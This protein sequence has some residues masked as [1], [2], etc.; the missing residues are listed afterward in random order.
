MKSTHYP[1]PDLNQPARVVILGAA[2]TGILTAVFLQKRH[3]D[4]FISDSGPISPEF[5]QDIQALQ[6]PFEEHGHQE[7]TLKEAD[8][9]IAS[10]G[11]PLL[12]KPYQI[13]DKYKIPVISEIEL[14][15]FFNASRIIAVTG[16]NGKSTTVTLI[17]Q[18]LDD[19]G[20]QASCGGNIGIPM[21]SL[22]DKKLDFIV[23]ELSSFQLETTYSLRPEIAILLNVYENHLDRHKD[24]ETYFQAKQRLFQAQ[25]Q[26]EHAILNH[27]NPWCRKVAQQ[28]KAQIHWFGH[29][30]KNGPASI[31][32]GTL[33]YQNQPLMPLSELALSG[34]HNYENIL[35]ALTTAAILKLPAETCLR[36]LRRFGGIPH[37][38]E[39]L[40][41]WQE[42]GF[43]NDSKAT[44]YLAAQTALESIS[45]PIVLIAGGQDKGGDFQPL[46]DTIQKKVHHVVLIGQSAEYFRHQL[47]QNGY[48]QCTVA[49]DMHTAVDLAYQISRPGDIILLSPA[50]AS[51]DSYRNFEERGDDF[52]NH[53]AALIAQ[54]HTKT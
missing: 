37:R 40:N 46:A 11:I 49:A 39:K 18:L 13:A 3:F 54:S 8:F 24:M 53:V 4:V 27:A 21:I 25:E 36:V 35:A 14:A 9:M 20:Y 41:F 44:N 7:S 12:A 22:L 50:T 15:S 45:Q 52:R 17:Q 43:I 31:Q 26:A 16:S 48:N 19:A 30:Q 38:L 34:K 33:Y 2:R 29:D 1:L 42:R 51:Y 23:L 6:I 10:P 32:A 5:K 28:T 47:A